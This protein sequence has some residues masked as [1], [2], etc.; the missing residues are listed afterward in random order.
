MNFEKLKKYFF[1]V[2]GSIGLVIGAVA[3]FLPVLPSFPFLVLALYGF[4]K[5]SEKLRN[6]FLSTKLY[7]NNLETYV[8]GK[9][10]TRKAKIRVM[11]TVTLFLSISLI[12]TRHIKELTILLSVIWLFHMLYFMYGVKTLG[13]EK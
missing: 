2:I 10:M 9:G 11:I 3:A 7:K 4:S 8:E 12:L 1:I 5:G 6:W 13:P